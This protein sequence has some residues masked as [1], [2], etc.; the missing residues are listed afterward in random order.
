[1]CGISGYFSKN[2]NS[3]AT[4]E[5]AHQFVDSMADAIK[6][7]GPDS[8]GKWTNGKNIVYGHRRL[9]ILDLLER[10]NQPMTSED[11]SYTII[12]NGEIYNFQELRTELEK[13]RKVFK[14]TGDTEVIL[15]LFISEKENL[16]QKLRGMFT[17]AIW[18]E[19][20]QELFLARDPYG[21][22]PLYYFNDND[23]LFFASQV[24]ALLATKNFP[25]AID[26]V[27]Q[28]SYWMFGS[29]QEPHTWFNAAKPVPAG[30]YAYINTHTKEI[31]WNKF[32]QVEEAWNAPQ[33][34]NITETELQEVVRAH[35]KDSIRKHL[36][37]DVPIGIFLSGGVDSSVVAALIREVTNQPLHGI[38][39]SFEEFQGQHE[40]EVP[41]A[42]IVAEKYNFQHYIRK[43]TAEEFKADLPAILASMDQPSIDGIN[44]WYA[45]KAAKE[46]KLKVVLSGIGGDELFMGYPSFNQIPK[47][48]KMSRLIRLWPLNWLATLAF[49]VVSLKTGNKRW[50]LIPKL[51]GNI[52][53]TY[54]LKRG[55]FSFAETI[56]ETGLQTAQSE[57]DFL[58]SISPKIQ[59]NQK[60]LSLAVGQLESTVYMRNQLLRDS[61]WASM[62]HSVELRT[63]LVDAW[64]AR[65]LGPYMTMIKNH[66][67]KALLAHSPS[68]PIPSEI[69]HRRKTGF[70]IP[71][72]YW[73][74]DAFKLDFEVNSSAP[75]T[76]FSRAWANI[77]VK[78]IY[79]T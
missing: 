15:Q 37:S 76:G 39:I 1:M 74:K 3:Q 22:K 59:I 21:I 52:F 36:V 33:I 65:Q 11:G 41:L 35:V 14:T 73:I 49:K 23:R 57:S 78:K 56:Q 24:K 6:N 31:T 68:Q 7:R 25:T 62:H 44:T 79:G 60:D 29:V 28:M 34:T 64:L 19:A 8:Y 42:K 54:W 2:T 55:L 9:S 66:G 17:I 69:L 47:L 48:A 30:H 58:N 26:P 18:N 20:K 71:L 75:K 61:D 51:S 67:G 63:P 16:L 4:L 77:L 50:P 13:Q 10:S 46:L 27:G 32:W 72:A 70:T 38:T 5:Q 53:G 43:V 12:F 45:S 40:D